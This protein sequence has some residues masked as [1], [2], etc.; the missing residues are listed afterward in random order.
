MNS[1][2]VDEFLEFCAKDDGL[3]N[4]VRALQAGPVDAF[5]TGLTALSGAHG[6]ALPLSM[7][8]E[9][10][11]DSVA[12]YETA[13]DALSDEQRMEVTAK[14]EAMTTLELSEE[15]MQLVAG[16]SG[17]GTVGMVLCSGGY[18]C[19]TCC[20]YG[21]CSSCYCPTRGVAC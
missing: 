15:E 9:W 16:G 17:T 8:E 2:R 5:S 3:S 11:R 21:N 19:R 7:V 4:S 20:P 18:Q 6:H 12:R 10:T 13:W 14:Y 1:Q